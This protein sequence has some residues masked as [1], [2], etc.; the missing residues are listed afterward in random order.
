MSH[1][2][3]SDNN[4]LERLRHSCAH[5]MAQAV[6]ELFP[7]TKITLGPTI[8]NGFYYDFDSEHRFSAED[9][10]QIE[11]RMKKIANG[12]HEF[13]RSVKSKEDAIRFYKEKQEKYKVEIIEGLPP[14]E[15]ISFY[16]HGT[17]IDLCRGPHIEDTGKIKHFKLLHVSGAYWRGDEKREM[18]QRIYG[19][20]WLTKEDLDNHLKR[21]EEAKKRD[22]RK[23]G[24]ELDLFSIEDEAGAGLIFWHPKGGLVRKL[25][26]DWLR[27][28][29]LKRGYHLV[30]TPH[31]MRLELWNTSGHTGFYRENM[32]NPIEFDNVKYQ[33]KPM[34]CPGHILIY[35]SRLHS[36]REL[37]IRLAELGTV[38]RYEKA[39]VMHGLM[40]VR[41]FT[42]DDAHIFCKPDQIEAE[43]AACI[44]FAHA[45]LKT[46]GFNDYKVELSTWDQS[47]PKDYAGSEDQWQK[48]ESALENTL[49]RLKIPFKK[50]EG[51][52]AFYGPKI[53]IK[54]VDGI[55]RLWQLTTVQFDFN[56]PARFALEY[57]GEDGKRHQPLMVHRALWGSVER[58]FGILIEHYAGAF[59]FWLAPVQVKILSIGE[60]AETYAQEVA[61]VLKKESFRVETNTGN[62]SIGAKIRD[63][64]MQK[65]PIMGV[66]GAK[67]KEAQTLTLRARDGKNL[68]TVKLSEIPGFLW[69]L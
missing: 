32:F 41:G 40:R 52:A 47:K 28:E 46:F 10:A 20:A 48:A 68:G 64:T 69:K 42:Q 9:L 24:T 21:L 17:F 34:N 49:N 56:L 6:Q 61:E 50:M 55:G 38:Y 18:L 30:F 60:T 27:D 63:A 13:V 12:N 7:G 31:I 26:E 51:E 35:K 22:H 3:H 58:F 16:Q 36:Y 8:E 67:E 14:T 5:V 19:T 23:L 39:G 1:S 2:H 43:V 33:L 53:D 37:P 25:M 45:A 62:D 44:D 11:N 65:V 54:L 4:T 29:L 59:P 57:V 15:E 66:A